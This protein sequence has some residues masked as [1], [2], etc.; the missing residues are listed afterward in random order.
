MGNKSIEAKR[1]KLKKLLRK[2]AV[3]LQRGLRVPN[4]IVI[5]EYK[6]RAKGLAFDDDLSDSVIQKHAHSL[7]RQAA[8]KRQ[9][10]REMAFDTELRFKGPGPCNVYEESWIYFNSKMSCYFIVHTDKKLH[11]ERRSIEYSCK[12]ILITKWNMNKT[13]WVELR[14]TL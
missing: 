11:I 9:A 10:D 4:R 3:P 1:Q 13:T 2:G 7:E 6:H 12:E 8:L 14:S 5:N